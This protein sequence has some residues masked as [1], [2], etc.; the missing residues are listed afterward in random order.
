[1]RGLSSAF[2][3]NKDMKDVAAVDDIRN[4]SSDN[5]DS[6]FVGFDHGDLADINKRQLESFQ[7]ALAYDGIDVS[8]Q[9]INKWFDFEEVAQTNA[10]DTEDS[11]LESAIKPLIHSVTG[12]SDCSSD[13]DS[14]ATVADRA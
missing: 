7:R 4:N 9:D 6:D 5:D 10:V 3:S 2:H 1:M 12:D 11:I 13:N 14:N 8:Q